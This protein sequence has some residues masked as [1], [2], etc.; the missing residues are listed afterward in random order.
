MVVLS[1]AM[2]THLPPDNITSKAAERIGIARL[3]GGIVF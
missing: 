1:S 2:R 3:A